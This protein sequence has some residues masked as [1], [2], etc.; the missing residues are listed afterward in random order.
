[1]M[2]LRDL[3]LWN[4]MTDFMRQ[5]RKDIVIDCGHVPV[6]YGDG[7]FQFGDA[8]GMSESI[9]RS[10]HVGLALYKYHKLEGRQAKIS[11]CLSDTS[12]LLG[13]TDARAKLVEAINAKRWQECLP[14]LYKS[15]LGDNELDDVLISLQT[16]NSNR[17]STL[18][19][20][21][22]VN[23]LREGNNETHYHNTGAVLLS[24]LDEDLFSISTS[25]LLNYERENIYYQNTMWQ[26]STYVDREKDI[27]AMPLT[28]LKRSG[29]INLYEKSSGILCP[30]TY[31]GLLLNFPENY[32]HI[33]VYAR[34]DDPYIGEK[35]IRG[36][37]ACNALKVDFSRQC[38]QIVYPQMLRTPELSFI[39]SD[40][41]KTQKNS[42]DDFLKKMQEKGIFEYMK[43]YNNQI[44]LDKGEA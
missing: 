4:E 7:R 11:I 38:L 42:F 35:I 19:K 24:S 21:S 1:M 34:N 43:F 12:R 32:D 22:K 41:L 14:E 26:K 15:Y 5:L 37:I 36:V 25:C 28:R 40:E 2:L 10:F 33:C 31:G 18:I 16:R 20:K 6:R 8:E 23:I 27:I 29:I 13:D 44:Q 3:P 39:N 17:F 30:A 9:I